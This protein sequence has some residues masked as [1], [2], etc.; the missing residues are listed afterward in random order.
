[1]ES[2]GAV[3]ILLWKN[4]FEWGEEFGNIAFSD[5]NMFFGV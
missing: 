2:K 4:W 1:M 5:I 3:F